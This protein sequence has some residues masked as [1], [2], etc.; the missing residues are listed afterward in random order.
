MITL[1]FSNGKIV[2]SIVQEDDMGFKTCTSLLKNQKF[3]WNPNNRWWE[4]SAIFYSNDL[5]D[6]LSSMA[7]VYF[8]DTAKQAIINYPK[9]LPSELIME[10]P[11]YKIDYEK[12]SNYKPIVGKTPFENF[13]DEDIRA[14]LGQNR[15]LFNWE[16]GCGKSFATSII[17]EYKK[18]KANCQKM[19]LFTTRIG[20]YNLKNELSKFCKSLN[21][22]DIEVFNSSKSFKKYGRNIF[23]NEEINNK[24]VL[25]FS[26]DSWKLVASSYGDKKR[27]R[28]SNV[29]IMNFFGDSEPLL[30]LD[31]CHQLSNPKSGRSK[32]IFKYLKYFKYR[33]L[34]SATPADKNEKIYSF[35]MV[36]DPKLVFYL[37]YDEWLQKYNDIGT[38]FSK[39]AINKKGW[40]QEELDALNREL[41]RYSVKRKAKEVLDLPECIFMDPFLISMSDKQKD[42]YK[43]VTNDI[44]N[45][46]IQKRPDMSSSSVDIVKEAFSAVMSLVENPIVLGSGTNSNVSEKLKEKC[47]KYNFQSDYAKLDVVDAILEDEVGDKENRGILWYIHPLTKDALLERYKDYDPIVITADMGEEE[48]FEKVEEFKKNDNHKILI[49]SEYIL[50]TSVTLIECTF[51][52]YLETAFSYETYLQS[53]GRIYRIGQK[54]QVRI[55]HIYYE[56]TVDTFHISAIQNK[57][58]LVDSLFTKKKPLFSLQQIK[59]IFQGQPA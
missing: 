5:F 8:P 39:Y 43:E 26:Y 48:R 9:T 54:Q 13:Q 1:G 38:W 30:C 20:T 24:K 55:Y 37:K 53:T 52:I 11:V 3:Q 45:N 50:A 33:Y 40:H 22:E 32:S 25:V 49:A 44:V 18:D 6:I 36:L 21:K 58:D 34:F 12:Y 17:Y 46:I 57:Q 42:L 23:D 31:E 16:M 29:P 14:A 28:N 2:A 4:K 41:N 27:G 56:N 51:A 15:Y 47:K 19:F 7:K 59:N 35:A 10:E